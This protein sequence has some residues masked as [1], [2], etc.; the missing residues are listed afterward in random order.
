MMARGEEFMTKAY[1][2]FLNIL[3]E[4]EHATQAKRN[5]IYLTRY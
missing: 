3:I 1:T 4:D 2:L 5:I